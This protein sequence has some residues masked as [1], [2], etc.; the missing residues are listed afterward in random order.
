MDS[1]QTSTIQLETQLAVLWY[2]SHSFFKV[3][4][5]IFAFKVDLIKYSDNIFGTP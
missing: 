5:E 3:F 2:R 4:L 1:H